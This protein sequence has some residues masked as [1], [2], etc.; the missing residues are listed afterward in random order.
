MKKGKIIE[1]VFTGDWLNPRKEKVYYHQLTIDNGDIGTYGSMEKL[2]NKIKVN[3]NIN[4]TIENG[5]I[6]LVDG[7][8]INGYKP[9]NNFEQKTNK[10]TQYPKTARLDSYLG[11][12]W[13]YA[14]DLVI[15][16]K[17]LEDYKEV[18]KIARLIYDEM[19]KMLNNIDD[20]ADYNNINEIFNNE[21][22]KKQLNDHYNSNNE[23]NDIKETKK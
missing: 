10:T 16:G 4:Y 15:A 6:K 17:S 18:Q 22:Y 3:E 11:Y 9:I 2:P 5:K 23:D 8:I 7:Q 14:K 19:D 21:N 13:S 12:A 1:C 20:N